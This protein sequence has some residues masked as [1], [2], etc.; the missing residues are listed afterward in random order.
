MDIDR[1]IDLLGVQQRK[2]ASP[3]AAP[4]AKAGKRAKAASK[5]AAA[6]SQQS[7]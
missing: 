3:A 4:P 2:Y 6:D 7:Y 1:K 5:P